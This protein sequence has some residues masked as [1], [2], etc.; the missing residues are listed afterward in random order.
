MMMV[1]TLW[2]MTASW[3]GVDPVVP[4]SRWSGWTRIRAGHGGC[5]GSHHVAVALPAARP[6]RDNGTRVQADGH[7]G[8]LGPRGRD[9]GPGRG[10][11]QQRRDRCAAVHFGAHGRDPRV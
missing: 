5:H 8:H 3:L 9:P 4:A 6:V 10:A 1:L 2:V 7:D 11:S